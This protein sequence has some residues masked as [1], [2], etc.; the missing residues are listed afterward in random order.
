MVEKKVDSRRWPVIAE[1]EREGQG[2]GRGAVLAW[3]FG[4]SLRAGGG[5]GRGGSAGAGARR[6]EA[7][8]RYHVK[9]GDQPWRAGEAQQEAS[10]GLGF[11]PSRLRRCTFALSCFPP[12]I[13]LA[14]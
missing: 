14:L 1:S 10:S 7:C 11:A 12:F 6:E 3:R 5:E 2:D 8:E 4:S 13:Q 9:S